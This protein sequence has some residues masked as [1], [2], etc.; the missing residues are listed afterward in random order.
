[1]IRSVRG[2]GGCQTLQR[3]PRF[4]VGRGAGPP[5]EL[6]GDAR[7]DGRVP[8]DKP[9]LTGRAIT[10]ALYELDA[11]AGEER[12]RE[13]PIASCATRPRRITAGDLSEGPPSSTRQHVA[14]RAQA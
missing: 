6:G 2:V 9:S 13:E 5:R 14:A 3:R 1:M 10:A 12:T 8:P 11:L 7:S 4:E